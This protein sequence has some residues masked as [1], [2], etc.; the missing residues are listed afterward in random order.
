M[1]SAPTLPPDARA[2]LDT[3]CADGL[4]IGWPSQIPDHWFNA[5]PEHD[6]E[7]RARFGALVDEAIAGGLGDW[8]ATPLGTLALVL[9]L[10]QLP[11]NLYRRQARAFAGD[12]RAQQVAA[13]AQDARV[14]EVLPLVGRVFLCMP[15]THAES[16]P[17]QDR[18]VAS[19]ERLRAQA[20]PE[21]HA[22]LDDHLRYARLHRDIVVRF[23]RFPHRNAVL[24]RESTPEEI[25]FL[26]DGPRFG[27]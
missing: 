4:A 7:L 15:F 25:E 6:A 19:F 23:G 12:A 2:L 8:T 16:L 10:D 26:K 13:A 20:A 24:G 9:L 21:H 1:P 14:D 17:L 3:W 5:T 11:R 18:C 22:T 27:Q